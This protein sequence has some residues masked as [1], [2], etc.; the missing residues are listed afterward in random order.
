MEQYL[1]TSYPDG[2]REFID[3]SVVERNIGDVDHSALLGILTVHVA[4]L[5]RGFG[6]E[7]LPSCRTKVSE[8]R[9]RVPDVIVMQRPFRETKSAVVDAP[10]IVIEILSP[11]DRVP[12][13]IERLR[14]YQQM[15]VPNIVLMDPVD[16]TTFLF[17]S[18]DLVQ[19][20]VAGFEVPGKGTLP[21]DI[22]ELLKRLDE[23]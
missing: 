4:G 16:R 14:D 13:T 8:T 17:F 1:R 15:G 6:L 12:E 7:V 20:D 5:K 19:R 21:F 10:L 3:G 9:C 18:G 2:D 23:E 11:E 22:R